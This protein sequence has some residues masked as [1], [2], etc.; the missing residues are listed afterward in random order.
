MFKR[1][2]NQLCVQICGKTCLI[3]GTV[4]YVC[5]V[6]DFINGFSFPAL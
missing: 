2:E 1:V 3:F 6:A 4:F 5:P